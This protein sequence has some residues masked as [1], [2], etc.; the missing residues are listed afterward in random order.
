MAASSTRPAT[1]ATSVR[2]CMAG[3]VPLAS[4]RLSRLVARVARRHARGGRLHVRL[5]RGGGL[6]RRRPARTP[7]G[8][9]CSR[10]APTARRWRCP[11]SWRSCARTTCGRRSSSPAAS[12]SATRSACARS[13][14]TGTRSATTATPTPRRR[15]WTPPPRRTSSSARSTVLRGFGADVVG[16][17]S[18]SWDFSP[19][20]LDLLE[21]HG[22]AYSS[23]LMDDIRP[24]RHPGKRLAELPDPVDPRR[25]RPLLVRRPRELDA[26]DLDA[27]RGARDLGGRV[28]RHPPP[29]RRLRP[30]HAPAGD[31]PAGPAAAPGGHDHPRARPEG[32]VGG[33]LPGAGGAR[34]PRCSHCSTPRARGRRCTRP[35]T[36]RRSRTRS[37]PRRRP[38]W[39]ERWPRPGSGAAIA[40]P[41]CC[42]TAPRS[43]RC[44]LRT[45][46]LG[47]AIAPLNPAYTEPEYRFFLDDLDPRMLVV[48]AGAAAAARA[49]AGTVRI[50]ELEP[51]AADG[52]PRLTADGALLNGSGG[53]RRRARRRRAAP[54]HERHDVAAQAGA[55]AAAQ[56]DRPGGRDRPPLRARQ[57]RTCRTARCRSSTCT[58]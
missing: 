46:A 21:Q 26:P 28:R 18:P 13:W 37:S 52:P 57:T 41:S 5:R 34:C 7:T 12:P 49:A 30:H 32:R 25:R 54:A 36:A 17:R 3:S 50:A 42:R 27:E 11:R 47:A 55:A 24:Y 23:N 53:R 33:H 29:R 44:C 8:P 1:E 38:A 35:T 6:D 15:T 45:A 31:R 4:V 40:S 58:A 10:R 22:F 39:P 14:P 19:R 20:T 56:P 2:T 43:W 9:A 48:A 16:Y 51:W